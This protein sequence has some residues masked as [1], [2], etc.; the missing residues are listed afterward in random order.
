MRKRRAIILGI[1][2]LAALGAGLATRLKTQAREK[3]LD[4]SAGGIAG[5]ETCPV[6]HIPF[7]SERVSAWHGT[8][9]PHATKEWSE[10]VAQ[11][12]ERYPCAVP[13]PAQVGDPDID[14]VVRSY[15]PDCREGFTAY[16]ANESGEPPRQVQQGAAGEPATPP[17]AGD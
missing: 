15:C 1:L 17:Q 16:V 2:A 12:R 13:F 11:A 14:T 7:S 10:R 5:F 8:F 3:V 9:S 6:H 4:V